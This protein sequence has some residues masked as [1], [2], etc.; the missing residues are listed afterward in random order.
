VSSV[1]RGRSGS[2]CL[3]R[4][5]RWKR[6]KRFI[7]QSKDSLKTMIVQMMIVI[8]VIAMKVS[9]MMLKSDKKG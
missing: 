7:Y 5:R 2:V 6:R 9:T 1:R 4:T 3:K 8:V